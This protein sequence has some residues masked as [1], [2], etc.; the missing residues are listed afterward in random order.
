MPLGPIVP[1]TGSIR[2]DRRARGG[3]NGGSLSGS[4][5]QGACFFDGTQ[6]RMT[7]IDKQVPAGQ[8]QGDE[9]R[10]TPEQIAAFHED[11]YVVLDD[12]V[13]EAELAP[14]ESLY[15]A[16][17]RGEVAGMNRDFCDMSGPYDRKFED[18][19]LVN[20]VLPRGYRGEL[21]GNVY[22]RRAASISRQLL[23]GDATLD[24][25]QFLAKRPK[26]SGAKFAWHQDLGYWPSTPHLNTLTATCS[27]ALDDADS[28]NGCLLVVPGSHREP[29]LRPHRPV[30]TGK[31]GDGARDTGHTLSIE[32][33]DDDRVVTL[34][35]KRGS[36][37]VHNERIIHGS[38]GNDSERWRRTY[39][40]AF[41]PRA[42]VDYERSIGFTHSHNDM[43]QW[44]TCLE[45]L[46]A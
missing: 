32:L 25:D 6:G 21:K 3:Y 37:S 5:A 40:V 13:S 16:F 14:L 17:I 28:D 44:Q 19:E 9:Y 15:D 35:V 20:A 29:A 31:A 2:G 1:E 4:A 11:G 33:T 18:F 39:I 22:E 30:F 23:G 10:L 12:V 36:V 46:E 24:Y 38:P 26:R 45:A 34:P 27:L 8:V 43:I 7:T 41:R 42:T